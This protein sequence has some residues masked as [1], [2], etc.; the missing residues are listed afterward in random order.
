MEA[1]PATHDL[2]T[3][4]LTFRPVPSFHQP[5]SSPQTFRIG[6][7]GDCAFRF[8]PQASYWCA[9]NSQGGGPGPYQ[10]PVQLVVDNSAESLPHTPYADPTGA[11]VHSWR[12][13]RWFSWAFKVDGA[14]FNGAN[15]KTTFNFSLTEG[16]NQGSRGGNAGQEFFVENILDELDAPSEWF[17]D[18]ATQTISLWYNGT[19]APPTDGSVAVTQL[20]VLINSTGTQA[21]PVVGLAFLGLTFADSAPFYLGPHGTPSGGDWAVGRSGALFFEGTEGLNITGCLLTRLDG[22]GI[23]MSGYTRGAV[24]SYNE[25]SWIGET[26]IAQVRA[27]HC[28]GVTPSVLS[29]ALTA[30]ILPLTHAPSY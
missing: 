16:G 25:M 8:T 30:N 21:K 9:D 11:V 2:P 14:A 27:A 22:N 5:T 10:A 23:F 24:V 26:A 12:A 19:G 20:H 7:G 18:E 4:R 13:G 17:F 29:R 1:S 28:Q 3:P 6:V 15:N